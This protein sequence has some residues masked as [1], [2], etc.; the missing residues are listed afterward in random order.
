MSYL[1]NRI[2]LSKALSC[3]RLPEEIWCPQQILARDLERSS[4]AYR[5]SDF[6]GNLSHI[7]PETEE[8]YCFYCTTLNFSENCPDGHYLLI[9]ACWGDTLS[10]LVIDFDQWEHSG[11]NLALHY[12]YYWKTKAY[13]YETILRIH[14][15]LGKL[16]ESCPRSPKIEE[17]PLRSLTSLYSLH[18]HASNNSVKGVAGQF[19]NGLNRVDCVNIWC[20]CRC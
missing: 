16:C 17:V 19:Q 11:Q 2:L 1:K 9:G 4:R 12:K 20:K 13:C 14:R 15:D 5:S 18:I 6:R 10:H 8:L 7:G 3:D